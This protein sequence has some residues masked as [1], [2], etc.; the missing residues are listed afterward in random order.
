MLLRCKGYFN[1]LVGPCSD[2]L[3]VEH[4]TPYVRETSAKALATALP[5]QPELFTQY[6][7]KLIGLYEEKV[8]LAM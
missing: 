7:D 6:L 2:D 3:T 4:E 1:C 5:A 8:V